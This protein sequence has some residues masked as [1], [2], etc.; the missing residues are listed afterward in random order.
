MRSPR[1][2]LAC[3]SSHQ[4]PLTLPSPPLGERDQNESLSLGEGEGRV[5]V[6]SLANNSRLGRLGEEDGI[7]LRPVLEPFLLAVPAAV[8]AK[9]DL[10]EAGLVA[11]V[12]EGIE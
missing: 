5:R 3:D 1:P 7:R 2:H 10:V 9:G 11:D 12:G 6:E 8:D 4:V